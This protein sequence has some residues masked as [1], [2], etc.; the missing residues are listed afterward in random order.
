MNQ[1]SLSR[2]DVSVCKYY[3][4]DGNFFQVK[5]ERKFLFMGTN[6]VTTTITLDSREVAKMTGKQHAHLMRDIKTYSKYLNE[7]NFGLVDFF[8][9]SKY[10][11][12]KGEIRQCYQITKKGCE[13]IAHKMT[14]KKGVQFTAQYINRF[15]EMENQ[16]KKPKQLEIQEYEYYDKTWN[17]K[18]I[19]TLRD[20]EHFTGISSHTMAYYLKKPKLFIKGTDYELL[21]GSKLAIFKKENQRI[22]RLISSLII[23]TKSGFD[24]MAKILSTSTTVPECFRLQKAPAP[25]SGTILANETLQELIIRMQDNLGGLKQMLARMNRPHT[26]EEYRQYQDAVKEIASNINQDAGILNKASI[27][28]KIKIV[29]LSEADQ[30]KRETLFKKVN[31]RYGIDCKDRSDIKGWAFDFGVSDGTQYFVTA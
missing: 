28:S 10:R 6:L 23:I 12:S 7:S 4:I 15:H 21:E 2:K 22:S 16:L 31:E 19:L 26:D 24:K 13:L 27:Q 11:D 29:D 1:V 3:I 20:L 25:E 9:T 18:P 17:G 8:V 5:F 30:R 14:G